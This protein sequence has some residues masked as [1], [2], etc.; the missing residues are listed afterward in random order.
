MAHNQ[1]FDNG[2]IVMVC[3]RRGMLI[4]NKIEVR[5]VF[6]LHF[7]VSLKL[8]KKKKK[9]A[10]F[11]TLTMIRINFDFSCSFIISCLNIY[12]RRINDQK[13]MHFETAFVLAK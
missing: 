7:C 4:L 9:G 1:Y 5:L 8:E 6:V 10:V 12:T 13:N 3:I 11:E 2:L